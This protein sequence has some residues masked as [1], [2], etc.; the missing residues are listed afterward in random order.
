MDLPARI[1]RYEVELELGHGDIGRVLLARDPVLGRQVVVKVLRAELDL[2]AENRARVTER[3]RQDACAAA[4]VSHPAIVTLHD[5]G[6][7]ER[8]GLFLVFELIR[9]PTL[10]EKLERG[11]LAPSDVAPLARALGSALT[12]AHGRGLVHRDVKPENVMLGPTGPKLTDFGWLA[13]D[14][15]A[16][17]AAGRSFVSSTPAY[18]APEVLALGAFSAYG[19]Q[20]S[21]AATLFEALTGLRAFPGGDAASVAA[22]VA[23]AKHPAATSLLPGLRAFPHVDPIFDRALAKEARNRFVSCEA[24]TSVLAGELEGSNVA[25]LT[26]PLPRSSIVPRAT[27]RW[28]NSAALLGVVV[29][30]LLAVAGRYHRP[31]DAHES[32]AIGV[33]LKSVASAFASC[34]ASAPAAGRGFPAAP[35]H[36]RAG[37][38]AS[39]STAT[40][41]AAAPPLTTPSSNMTAVPVNEASPGAAPAAALSPAIPQANPSEASS[42]RLDSGPR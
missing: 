11:P 29:I 42:A 13:A 12:H 33:S 5:M 16:G 26:T 40:S 18:S 38:S 23:T 4:S 1:G 39:S 36:S 34:L 8:V 3:I 35:H 2:S 10:R 25:T 9:G 6:E 41:S 30:V 24:F 28:Q 7:D 37:A 14:A 20:F 31:S 17:G 22:R 15:F 32:H 27:R 21:L 19:D